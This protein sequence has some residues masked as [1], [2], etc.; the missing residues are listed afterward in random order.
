MRIIFSED[1]IYMENAK[2]ATLILKNCNG[3]CAFCPANKL[4]NFY[5]YVKLNAEFNY[6]IQKLTIYG[7][8][9][10]SYIRS[11]LNQY[12]LKNPDA[13]IEL[14]VCKNTIENQDRIVYN[15]LIDPSISNYF[16]RKPDKFIIPANGD[17]DLKFAYLQKFKSLYP[18]IP[19][20][21][22]I[23]DSADAE[24]V[25]WDEQKIKQFNEKLKV[26]EFNKGK[27]MN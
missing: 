24:C 5:N 2:D 13:K 7:S 19:I 1:F 18:H 14:N 25:F 8:A 20:E 16:D 27:Q 26:A 6:S 4:V 23:L 21:P 11:F 12:R 10:S 9:D 3:N 15:H 22:V 17:Q